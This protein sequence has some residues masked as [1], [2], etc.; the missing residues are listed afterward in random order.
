MQ[1]II[2]E[3]RPLNATIFGLYILIFCIKISAPAVISSLAH[4]IER[5]SDERS[6]A[7][8][9][10]LLGYIGSSLRGSL[11]N[12]GKANAILWHTIIIIGAE[13]IGYETGHVQQFP[14]VI[15]GPTVMVTLVN[16]VETWI[17]ANLRAQE[18]HDRTLRRAKR[19]TYEDNVEIRL[20]DI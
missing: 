17:D 4:G 13:Y 18:T 5:S 2:I 1:Q 6:H 3:P 20:K 14:E 7:N 15:A 11:H 10:F 9:E 19:R 12:I 16:S 8:G